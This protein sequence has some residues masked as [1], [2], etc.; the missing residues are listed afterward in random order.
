MAYLD[1]YKILGVTPDASGEDIK[2]SYR[3][4]VLQFHPDRNQGS[5]GAEAKI[6]EVNAAYEVLGNPESRK[7][8]ERLRFGTP[9]SAPD[10]YSVDEKE[11]VNP[12]VVLQEMEKK[13]WDEAR[14]ELFSLLMKDLGKIKA[15]LVEIRS[16][17]VARQRYDTFRKDV[18]KQRG[19]EILSQ[20]VDADM[21]ERKT[22][23]INV[24]SQMM[25]S[26]GVERLGNSHNADWLWNRLNAAYEQGRLDAF[27]E[28]CELLYARR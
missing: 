21:E 19:G 14:R 24:A 16:R 10:G 22:R 1:F 18:V 3:K 26:Q 15:E 23:L 25:L 9:S 8:Y 6:L 11:A 4:L 2:K 17:T 13:L 12:A 5:S 28:A 27:L 20:F 7:S